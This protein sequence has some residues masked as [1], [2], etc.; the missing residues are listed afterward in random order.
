MSRT[1]AEEAQKA[2]YDKV[3][4]QY[5][6]HQLDTYSQMYRKRFFEEVM[7]EGVDLRGQKALEAMC[8]S[9]GMIAHLLS[10]G[11]VVSGLDISSEAIKSFKEKWPQCEGI[12]GSILGSNI[13][14]NTFDCVVIAGGLHHV[15]PQVDEAVDEIYR[16]LKP[17]GYFA[18]MEPHAGALPDVAR[19]LW[20]KLDRNMFAE[21]EEA[22]DLDH[23]MQ[24]N[25]HRFDF[26]KTNYTGNIG[27][28]LVLNSLIFRIPIG[29]KKYYSPFLMNVEEVIGRFQGKRLSCFVVGQWRKK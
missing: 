13:A 1:N 18:F 17:G 29:W 26:L 12:E 25:K 2:H 27:Y 6:L 5:N 7:T 3:M 21:N 22:I 10:K 15:Q 28:L 14:D 16:I 9:G 24:V 23:M 19:R 11:A 8:G 4:E 20:Y